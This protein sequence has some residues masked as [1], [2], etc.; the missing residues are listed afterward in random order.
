MHASPFAPIRRIAA[1]TAAIALGVVGALVGTADHA[2]AA[3]EPGLV[4]E[5]P[6]FSWS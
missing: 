1:L 3:T 6:A 4:M 5:S 2:V